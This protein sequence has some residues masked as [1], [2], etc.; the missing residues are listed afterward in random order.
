MKFSVA[1]LCFSLFAA[2]ANAQVVV[3]SCSLPINPNCLISQAQYTILGY[4][5]STNIGAVGSTATA[6]NYNATILVQ[7]VYYSANLPSAQRTLKSGQS[8]A[9]AGFG[10]PNPRCPAGY[11]GSTVALNQSQIFFVYVA[12]STPSVIYGLF[13]ICDSPLSTSYANL[14]AISNNIALNPDHSIL[15][16]GSNCALPSPSAAAVSSVSGT[17]GPTTMP[18]PGSEAPAAA[19]LGLGLL[20]SSVLAVMAAVWMH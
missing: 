19:A 11:P 12:T 18:L 20:V 17:T 6:S 1:A 4:A 9:V 8:I 10:A 13:D 16:G 15:D 7:C 14:Q 5:V 2:V 3:P